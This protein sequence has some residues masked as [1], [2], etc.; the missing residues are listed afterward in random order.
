MNRSKWLA[1]G[2]L[3]L[4]FL[5]GAITG[6]AAIAA[7]QG[8]ERRDVARR[9]FG[10]RGE[11]PMLAM[12]RRLNLDTT[13]R[14]RI[15]DLLERHAPKRHQLMQDIM[16]KCGQALEA[17][18]VELDREIRAVLRPEQQKRFDELS[19]RQRERLFGPPGPPGPPPDHSH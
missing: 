7:W 1:A 9:G 14:E 11:R 5:L 17:E 3:I 18:K 19:V 12:M 8:H 15:E 4:V 6:G 2:V 16:A 13:Q 10:M